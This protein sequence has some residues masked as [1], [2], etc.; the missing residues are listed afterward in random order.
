MQSLNQFDQFSYVSFYIHVCNTGLRCVLHKLSAIWLV[1]LHFSTLH[2]L[3]SYSASH[4]LPEKDGEKDE[5]SQLV[6]KDVSNTRAIKKRYLLCC[7]LLFDAIFFWIM[8][9][10]Q[11]TMATA[12]QIQTEQNF[13]LYKS[14]QFSLHNYLNGNYEKIS[15]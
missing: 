3:F 11:G 4:N 6:N 13:F 9:E 12:I 10:Q 5:A 15:S 1:Q 8:K 7:V 2:F 14:S